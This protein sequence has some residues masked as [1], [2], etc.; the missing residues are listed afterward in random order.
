MDPLRMPPL[1]IE[2]LKTAHDE[3]ERLRSVLQA[4][5]KWADDLGYYSEPGTELAPVFQLAKA[6][7]QPL[8][9]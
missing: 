9:K 2:Q 4:V 1:L 8:S 5:V 6:A 7:L 3:I